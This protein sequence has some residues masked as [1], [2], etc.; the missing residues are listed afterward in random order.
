MK[1]V[2]VAIAALML[3]LTGMANAQGIKMTQAEFNKAGTISL[4]GNVVG[5][6]NVK[7]DDSDED[8]SMS[9]INPQLGYMAIENLQITLGINY[10]SMTNGDNESSTWTVT[11]GVR[12][13]LDM[14]SKNN[15]FPH[16]GATFGI[17]AME[18]G[19]AKADMQT[20][21]V[22]AGITQAMGGAQGGFMT[23]GLDYVM[24]TTTPDAEGAEDQ[25]SSGL[26]VGVA[27]GL[28]F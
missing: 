28:Y 5:F 7:D 1:K 8:Q 27:F 10:G 13:Y 18:A 9:G 19:E 11:P 17:G 14:L 2:L 16:V 6:N 3:S 12:Y 23:L 20:I 4:S 25:N 15:L 24:A 22:G 21:T 26:N